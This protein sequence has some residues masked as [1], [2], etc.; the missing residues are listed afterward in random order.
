MTDATNPWYD[1]TGDTEM[2]EL[3][4][5]ATTIP[6]PG[7]NEPLDAL[8]ERKHITPADLVRV[9]ARL[10]QP[11][12]LGFF[13]PEGVK[14]RDLITQRRWSLIESSF[15][16]S[17][18][19]PGKDRER[20]VVVEGETD[21][22]R[23]S[24]PEGPGLDVFIMAGGAKYVP[25]EYVEALKRYVEVYVA[26]DADDAG[27][28]G[29]HMLE[30]KLSNTVRWRPPEGQD[31]CSLE[32]LPVLPEPPKPPPMWVAGEEL[33]ELTYPEVP[34]YFEHALLPTTGML[35]VH[36]WKNS[37]KSWLTWDMAIALATGGRWCGFEATHNQ[38]AVGIVQFEVPPTYYKERM[39][40][41]H[42][43]LTLED[44]RKF[45]NLWHYSPLQL[46]SWN[47]A[48]IKHGAQFIEEVVNNDIKVVVCDPVRQ[49]VGTASMND[50]ESQQHIVQLFR[51]LNREGVAVVCTHHDSKT[52]ARSPTHHGSPL[53]MT[54]GDVLAGAADS[55]C[56]IALPHGDDIDTSK[57]RNLHFIVRGAPGVAPRGFEMTDAGPVY[58]DEAFHS[59]T[60]TE[61]APAF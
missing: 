45:G 4:D 3:Y 19:V 20:C 54:A 31:W 17:R 52:A 8:C 1:Y 38:V 9:G 5:T 43:R 55:I 24:G 18:T 28:I 42:T 32:T 11:T 29:A 12:V 33:F 60:P 48:D 51:A 14:Y 15:A 26:L 34:S 40:M 2:Q 44:Q 46:P 61:D 39:Q 47:V 7:E 50:Q 21:A 23:M 22:A 30:A 37:Y 58:H 25:I 6:D 16:V 56:S 41:L 59:D 36:G 27:D 49:M 53:A 57:R 10:T 35:I 13:Y